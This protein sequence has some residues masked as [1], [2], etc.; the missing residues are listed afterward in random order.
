MSTATAVCPGRGLTAARKD[1]RDRQGRQIHQRRS[2]HHRCTLLSATPCSGYRRRDR[3][4]PS[5]H[6]A[7]GREPRRGDDRWRR[8]LPPG[9]RRRP[10]ARRARDRQGGP[11][12]HRARPPTPP[13]ATGDAG[14]ATRRRLGGCAAGGT[15][16]P[17]TCGAA[18]TTWGTRSTPRYSR[19][20]H[21]RRRRGPPRVRLRVADARAP[22]PLLATPTPASCAPQ[23]SPH[24]PTEA[25][26][27]QAAI[28]RGA[29]CEQP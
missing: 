24:N 27:R 17:A 26:W 5:R 15:P 28:P 22:P 21:R 16:S 25:L 19:C 12:A 13:G 23:P 18:S 4:L 3:V 2:C 20:S 8:R 11:A 9:A 14:R 1:G 7:H 6:R 29:N 10:P